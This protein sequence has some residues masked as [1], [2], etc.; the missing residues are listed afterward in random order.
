MTEPYKPRPGTFTIFDNTKTKSG[1]APDY[2]GEIVWL[3]G[4]T[5]DLAIWI[6]PGQNGPF[7]S[8]SITPKQQQQPK[9]EP[10]PATDDDAPF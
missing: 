7:Y 5:M 3:D 6:K 10:P 2:K 8:G 1:R 9:P 4:V